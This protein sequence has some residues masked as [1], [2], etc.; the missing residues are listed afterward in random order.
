VEVADADG[1]VVSALI[2]VFDEFGSATVV[3]ELDLVLNSRLLGFD[4]DGP[5]APAPGRRPVH[6][7]APALARTTDALVG[8][9]T[10]G[11]DG[12][13]QTLLQ[14][15]SA[16][17]ED[18]IDLDRSVH[19]PRWR[20]IDGT[21]AVED[22]FPAELADELARRDHAVETLPAGD[23]LFGAVAAV[24]TGA[25]GLTAVSD[26]RRETWAGAV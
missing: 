25:D 17:H 23:G 4:S 18:G 20:V 15:L 1:L 7:L 19:L 2:S 8:I 3:P 21:V 9:A 11:A 5:N 6:T 16:V 12:Q 10:P 24:A 14:V 26:P 22:G 13:I